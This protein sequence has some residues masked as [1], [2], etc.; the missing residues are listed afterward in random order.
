MVERYRWQPD[1]LNVRIWMADSLDLRFQAPRLRLVRVKS[2]RWL[3]QDRAILLGMDYLQ[4]FGPY[5]EPGEAWFLY[6]FES[7]G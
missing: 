2:Q 4:N 7:G 3:A 1:G 5:E 6:D